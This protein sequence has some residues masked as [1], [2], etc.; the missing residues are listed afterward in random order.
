ML[1]S[2]L[3]H[4]KSKKYLSNL[5]NEMCGTLPDMISIHQW[6]QNLRKEQSQVIWKRI[7]SLARIISRWLVL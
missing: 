4:R 3:L 2:Y 5:V 7:Y 6:H 1:I